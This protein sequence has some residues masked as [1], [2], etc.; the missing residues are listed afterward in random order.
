MFILNATSSAIGGSTFDSPS[1]TKPY[2]ETASTD[3]SRVDKLATRRPGPDAKSGSHDKDHSANKKNFWET[4]IEFCKAMLEAE[5]SITKLATETKL[6]EGPA[7][8]TTDLSKMGTQTSPLDT[9]ASKET[10]VT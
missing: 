5:K 2:V 8:P 9:D 3:K 1:Y 6:K 4:L 7:L 10:T